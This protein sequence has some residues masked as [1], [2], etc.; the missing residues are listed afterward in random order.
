MGH[1][2]LLLV[3]LLVVE[4]QLLVLQN[5]AVSTTALAGARG[6][7]RQDLA[8][9]QLLDHLLLVHNR[10]LS[11][12]QLGNRVL[13]LALQLRQVV[14]HHGALGVDLAGVVLLEPRLER[15]GI[16]RHDAALHDRV[17]AHQLVVGGV[18]HDVQDL[19]LGGES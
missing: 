19:R 5:V 2:L 4:G 3:D 10:L 1:L 15:R 8:G 6:D 7:A 11:L 17:R 9:S 13:A 12:L 14:L 18:V 16:D